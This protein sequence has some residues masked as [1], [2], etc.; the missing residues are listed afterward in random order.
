MTR[1]PSVLVLCQLYYPEV[2]STGQ[3]MTELCEEM[4]KLGWQVEVACGWPSVGEPVEPP[5][6]NM[7]HRGVTINRLVSS[8]FPKIHFL[9]KLLNHLTFT[10]SAFWK[11]LGNPSGRPV[12][13]PT[14]PPFLPFACLLAKAFRPR[15]K[16][17]LVMFDIYPDT[18]VNLGVLSGT[19]LLA[20]CWNRLNLYSFLKAERVI[21]LGRCMERVIRAK[22]G[23]HEARIQTKLRRVHIWA[24]DA[25]IRQAVA[26]VPDVFLKHRVGSRFVVLY[27][28]NMGWF[29]DME[30]V[31]EAARILRED[32]SIR[33]LFIGE[34]GKKAMV[35]ET[36][37]SEDL[38]NC[39]VDTYVPKEQLPGLL[40]SSH[41]GIATLLPG[42]EGLSVPSKTL[43]IMAAGIPVLAVM[44]KDAEIAL[45]ISERMAGRV[46][47]NGDAQAL[48][49]AIRELKEDP[50]LRKTLGG[51]ALQ[52]VVEDLNLARAAEEYASILAEA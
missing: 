45:T 43:G 31:L 17:V 25:H 28:G 47:A 19:G 37:R 16:I 12:L 41:V 51:N 26:E 4:A 35:A 22:C 23:R 10:F 7:T 3:T 48:V 2:V 34:G 29:H 32:D 30:T 49:R 42:Q 6:W 11:L 40:R 1:Q 14:N 46:V 8:K 44:A 13:V 5:A 27:S 33:F 18:A 39:S 36:V 9:G 50:A 52:A 38:K 21:V 15:L 24:D 20:R